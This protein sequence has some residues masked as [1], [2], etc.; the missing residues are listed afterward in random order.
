[1]ERQAGKYPSVLKCV[2]SIARSAG[3][4]GFYKVLPALLPGMQT[5]RTSCLL[6]T[7]CSANSGASDP[8]WAPVP[9][10]VPSERSAAPLH[11]AARGGNP[12]SLSIPMLSRSPAAPHGDTCL[13][14]AL[15]VLR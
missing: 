2:T 15:R 14:A 9:V 5:R 10:P 12:L 6:G 3:P 7:R 4:K 1:M 11:P 8:A 13:A